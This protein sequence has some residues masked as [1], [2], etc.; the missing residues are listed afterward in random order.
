VVVAKLALGL[1][2]AREV[3]AGFQ[4]AMVGASTRVVLALV[5]GLKKVV[6]RWMK[7]IAAEGAS[8]TVIDGLAG[9]EAMGDEGEQKEIDTNGAGD[10]GRRGSTSPTPMDTSTGSGDIS[11][12]GSEECSGGAEVVVWGD[13]SAVRVKRMPTEWRWLY[14]GATDPVGMRMT[15]PQPLARNRSL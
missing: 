8:A 2:V 4:T 15:T 11:M 10:G 9:V 12:D 13:P 14:A 5:A 6:E 3:V 7:T 1:G